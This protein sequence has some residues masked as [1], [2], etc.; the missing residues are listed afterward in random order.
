MTK[1]KGEWRRKIEKSNKDKEK[2]IK[3]NRYLQSTL[4]K[5]NSDSNEKVAIEY[6][7]RRKPHKKCDFVDL[8]KKKMV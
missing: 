5:I 8:K 4:L 7:R 2:A 6:N 1:E 3:F